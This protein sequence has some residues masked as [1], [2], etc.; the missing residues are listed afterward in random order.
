MCLSANRSPITPGL[1]SAGGFLGMTK[2]KIGTGA[3][4]L[5]SGQKTVADMPDPN[6]SSKFKGVRGSILGG[7]KSV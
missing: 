3:S 5:T 2:P 1:Q 4:I 7:M 6:T